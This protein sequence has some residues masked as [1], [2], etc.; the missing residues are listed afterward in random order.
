MKTYLFITDT[1]FESGKLTGGHKR[2]LELVKGLSRNSYVIVISRK[3]PQ[4]LNWEY[5]NNIEFIYVN[6]NRKKWLPYH[7]NA[8]VKLTRELK[9]RKTELQY[10]Y[11]VAFGANYA[12]AYKLAGYKHIVSLFREDLLGYMEAIGASR[13]KKIYL[14]I[15]EKKAVASSD[16]IIVQCI[17]DKK[18]LIKRTQKR[19]RNVSDKVF[20]QI[21]NANASWMQTGKIEHKISNDRKVI[22]LFIGGFSDRRK[23]HSVLLPAVAKLLD[24][25]YKVKLFIA[26]D[27]VE[28]D[29]YKEKYQGYED[30]IFLGRVSNISYYL[31]MADFTVVPSLIDSCPN[32]VLES[33]NAGIAV[34]GANTGGIPDL[35]VEDKFLFEPDSDNIYSFLKNII[36]N[37]RYK[38]DAIEQMKRKN[39]LTFDWSACIQNIIEDRDR[40]EKYPDRKH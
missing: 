16:K 25:N 11:A 12:L 31:S 9:K 20:I 26:G 8:L 4:L 2:L 3:I 10:D 6:G 39:D 35:L 17:N 18:N 33:L 22:I 24:H 5:M 34:Y 29:T 32:T 28:L 38:A 15:Q 21:N 1:N 7:L 37:E 23:G 40:Q 14:G 27:G 36:A 30:L 13:L 19:E